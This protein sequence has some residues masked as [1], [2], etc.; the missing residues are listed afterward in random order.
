MREMIIIAGPN[1]A[2]KTS[3][4]NAYLPAASNDLTF[5]NADEIA[6]ELP[7]F[8][9]IAKRD[10][11]AG[12]IMLQRIDGLTAAGVELLFE[13]TLASLDYAKKI[14]A[15]QAMGYGVTL[16]YL[17][18][19]SVESSL[20][21]VRKRV[22]AGGHDIPEDVVRRRFHRSWE[23]LNLHYKPIVNDWYVFDSLEGDFHLSEQ[24]ETK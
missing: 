10:L 1:G 14:P 13:T 24:S 3:F 17:R 16:V 12:R 7:E 4:A 20:E 2:G 21:R 11:Q 23:Y 18:L 15:W 19:P 9:S 5:V 6:R 8:E 22:K